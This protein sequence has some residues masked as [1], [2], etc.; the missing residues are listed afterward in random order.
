MS[1]LDQLLFLWIN[2]SATP[3]PAL[4]AVARLVADGLIF[5]LPPLL[6]WLWLRAD[7]SWRRA[8]LDA[9]F[10][11]AVALAIGAAIGALWPRSRPFA[12]GLGHRFIAHVADASFPSDHLSLI[13]A[14]AASWWLSPGRRRP[15]ALLFVTG[16]G[17]AWA[18]IFVGVHFPADMV[19]A[20]AVAWVGAWAARQARHVLNPLHTWSECLRGRMLRRAIRAGLASA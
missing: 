14:V 7:A 20:M 9:A 2:A 1:S 3:A 17:V 13:W 4:L 10:S 6:A 15:A 18:R 16:L 19:G 12:L 11:V 5:G 8:L